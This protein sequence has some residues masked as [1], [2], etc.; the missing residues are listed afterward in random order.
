M[1]LFNAHP[2]ARTARRLRSALAIAA[3]AALIAACAGA[4]LSTQVISTWKDPKY[5]S[6]PLKKIFVISLMKIEP[7]GRD[8]V[9]DA[10]VARLASAGV[11][12]VA[13]HTVM[14][15]DPQRP[16]PSLPEA[17]AA[18]GADG[19]LLVNVRAIGSYE[20]YTIGQTVTSLSPDTMASYSYLKQQG[21][22][23]KGDYK[24]AHIMSELYLPS[25]GKQVWTAF[26]NSYDASNLARNMPDY[27]F[28]LVTVMAKDRIIDGVPAPRS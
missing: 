13:S 19:V 7:G 28:K 18:S 11:G 21:A 1:L 2:L 26:T 23:Q 4:S 10:V 22:D 9:E 17:I 27:T 16:G 20:P 12:G 15:N 8:A 6:A 24:V 5:A 14:S 3:G 25:M